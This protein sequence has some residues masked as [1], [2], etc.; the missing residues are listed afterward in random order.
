MKEEFK[1]FTM[2]SQMRDFITKNNIND[3]RTLLK[4]LG[5]PDIEYQVYWLTKVI[6]TDKE[7]YVDDW[8][9]FF[10]SSFENGVY[11]ELEKFE[12]EYYEIEFSKWDFICYDELKN[13]LYYYEFKNENPSKV[14]ADEVGGDEAYWTYEQIME[15][16]GVK[17]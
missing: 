11:E 15:S 16:I 1:K 7:L 10:D 2:S 8:E 13:K 6:D 3:L 12:K 5:N 14:Y 9:Y 17:I 4:E